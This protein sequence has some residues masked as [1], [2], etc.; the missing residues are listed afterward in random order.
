MKESNAPG[1]KAESPQRRPAPSPNG[2]A[3]VFHRSRRCAPQ[4]RAG[5]RSD[6]VHAQ[7]AVNDEVTMNNDEVANEGIVGEGA[8][9][10][11]P[12]HA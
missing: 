3:A 1:R 8:G 12:A 5:R 11:R 7:P 6:P 4:G 9:E 10:G 2:L